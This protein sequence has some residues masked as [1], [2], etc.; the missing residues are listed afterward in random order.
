M[1]AMEGGTMGSAASAADY[2]FAS[3]SVYRAAAA[4]RHSSGFVPNM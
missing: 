2:Q 4:G 3:G 1:V